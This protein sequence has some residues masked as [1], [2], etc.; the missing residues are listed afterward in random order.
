MHGEY[1]GSYPEIARKIAYDAAY[2]GSIYGW[3]Y[4]K[5]E[6]VARRRFKT[7]MGISV[8]E[9]DRLLNR[10]NGL[11]SPE[12]EAATVAKAQE[13]KRAPVSVTRPAAIDH[14]GGVRGGASWQSEHR[15]RVTPPAVR[16]SGGLRGGAAKRWVR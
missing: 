4:E 13:V 9:G 14:S 8:E 3:S 16:H 10:E 7:V 5:A 15:Q 12:E 2:E 1:K 11:V 6:R